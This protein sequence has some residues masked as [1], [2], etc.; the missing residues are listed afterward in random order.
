[1]LLIE[2]KIYRYH[3]VKR[4]NIAISVD[5]NLLQPTGRF[6]MNLDA[7]SRAAEIVETITAR[8]SPSDIARNLASF[9]GQYGVSHLLVTGLPGSTGPAWQTSIVFDGWPEEWLTH[10]DKSGMFRDDPCVL[11]S[12][13]TAKPFLWSELK[14]DRFSKEQHRVM[15]EAREF[16]LADG[17]CLPIH[18]P[19]QMPAVITGAGIEVQ[20]DPFEMAIIEM[21]GVSS[22]RAMAPNSVATDAAATDLSDREKE[23]LEWIAGGKT[24]EDVACIL[25]ISR[26]TVE[27]HLSNI[28][29]RTGALN[30]VHAVVKALKNG[31]IQP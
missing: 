6:F 25:A 13:S 29:E 7:I 4:P 2:Y 31:D 30:T 9:L 5:P 26:P 22:F 17:M 14:P 21:V 15:D 1:M 16:D 24:A 19:C 12:R 3:C 11:R 10:Y 28:R 23:V 27:R 8:A 20:A 18:G